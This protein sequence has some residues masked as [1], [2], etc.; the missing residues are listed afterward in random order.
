MGFSIWAKHV[1]GAL[2]F[3]NKLSQ[4][5]YRNVA[6]LLVDSTEPID[7]KYLDI[8]NFIFYIMIVLVLM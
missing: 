3:I 4:L 6:I 8:K 7:K 2:L 1:V 5:I